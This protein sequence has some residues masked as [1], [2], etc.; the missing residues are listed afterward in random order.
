[1]NCIRPVKPIFIYE[2]LKKRVLQSK[3]IWTDDSPVKVQGRTHEKNVREGRVWAYLGDHKNPYTA[4]D[5]TNSRRRDGPL[6]FL[7]DFAG[8]LQA[9]AFAGYDCIYVGVR[10]IEVACLAHARRKFYDCLPSDNH[11][12]EEVLLLISSLYNVERDIRSADFETRRT[13]E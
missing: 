8:Y 11:A 7:G 9:D 2:H 6:K 4:Y 13:P 10:V 5:F 12:D 1:M 3:I